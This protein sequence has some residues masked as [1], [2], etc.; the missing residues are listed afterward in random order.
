MNAN[1]TEGQLVLQVSE[2]VAFVNQTLEVA[3]PFVGIEGEVSSFRVSKGKWVYF[4]LKDAVATVRCFTTVYALSG[5][6]EDGMMVRVMGTPRLHPLYNFTFNVQTVAAVGE[7]ALRRQADLL[8][9]KLEAEGLFDTTR[10]RSLPVVP[11]HIALVAS[12][13][14]AAYA[15]FIKIASAR[16]GS[17][18]IDHYEVQ[19]QGEAAP[20]Q[21]VRAVTAANAQPELPEVVVL[22]RGGGSVEDLAAF[23]D[24][25]VVRAVAA[26]RVP[27]MVAI[28]HEVD[29]A[30]AEL[31]ADVRASTPSNAAELL[32]PD[33]A[34]EHLHL[35]AKQREFDAALSTFIVQKRQYL[36]GVHQQLDSNLQ[37]VLLAARE[38]VSLLERLLTAL[39][40]RRPLE[41]GYALVRNGSGIM[42]RAAL[43]NTHESIQIEFIDGIVAA[44]VKSVKR[45][46]A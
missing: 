38:Q 20:E 8:R 10:K 39:D 2:F 40:P 28:G 19:V 31:A 35:H 13:Q 25:R 43:A 17:L 45:K 26:S 14:S 27:T 23:S 5:P 1:S 4:D 36:V 21:I 7:G 24:E 16:W 30:L 37:A 11:R 15:D 46:G 44:Q 33:K 6:L 3:Y 32:L 12:G 22:V 41:Q 34:E 42:R 29:V 9:A 18:V